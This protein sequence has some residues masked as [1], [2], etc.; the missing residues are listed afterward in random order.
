MTV[1][2]YDPE[3]AGEVSMRTVY[4]PVV[5]GINS[6]ISTLLLDVVELSHTTS[7]AVKMYISTLYN[8]VD[9]SDRLV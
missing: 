5:G 6:I 7:L 9:I 1:L 3:V 8:V 2:L 4:V